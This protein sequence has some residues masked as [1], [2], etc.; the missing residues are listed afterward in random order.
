MN[1]PSGQGRDTHSPH[2]VVILVVDDE[3]MVR[4]VVCAMLARK[5]YGTVGAKD[6]QEAITLSRQYVG[7][8]DLLLTDYKMP[9]LNGLELAAIIAGERP[10][11]KVLMMSGRLSGKL[12]ERGLTVP[13]LQKPF[14]IETL[15]EKVR[16]A[17]TRS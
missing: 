10:G 1:A 9:E 12:A 4:N 3:P 11:I 14:E 13:F 6:G 15:W 7:T 16:E 2:G 5:G 17:L 8:I